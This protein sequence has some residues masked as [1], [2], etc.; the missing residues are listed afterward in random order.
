METADGIFSS[1]EHAIGGAPASCLTSA[2][3]VMLARET[4]SAAG[5]LFICLMQSCLQPG[6]GCHQTHGVRGLHLL[7]SHVQA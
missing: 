4:S 5:R 3:L 2:V 6:Q 7:M 1:I